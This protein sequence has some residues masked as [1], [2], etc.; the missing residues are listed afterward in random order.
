MEGREKQH[1]DKYKEI[2]NDWNYDASC[3]L[4]SLP[5]WDVEN[6]KHLIFIA[7]CVHPRLHATPEEKIY[8]FKLGD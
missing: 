5:V 8:R 1:M 4:M 7:Q 6:F 3:I 2:V